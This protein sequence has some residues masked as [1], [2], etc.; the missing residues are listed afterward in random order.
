LRANPLIE[1]AD[2][3]HHAAV[4]IEERRSPRQGE[5]EIFDAKQRPSESKQRIPKAQ[6]RGAPTSAGGVEQV[7]HP[8]ALDR[9]GHGNFGQI[10]FGKARADRPSLGH[11]AADSGGNI[12]GAFIAKHLQR[13]SRRDFA[14]KG[15]VGGIFAPGIG[16]RG[17]KAAHGRTKTSTGNVH[18]HCLAV[19]FRGCDACVFHAHAI[20]LLTLGCPVLWLPISENPDMGHPLFKLA[21]KARDWKRHSCRVVEGLGNH[22]LASRGGGAI[23][24]QP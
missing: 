8:L 17:Q 6:K 22:D 21:A 15:G 13:H 7:H 1:L 23:L 20:F 2:G 5:G 19:D 12:I 3:H 10:Q 24:G 4:F 9:G 14:F 16:Q 18:F 11:H